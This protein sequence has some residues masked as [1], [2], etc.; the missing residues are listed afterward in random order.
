MCALLTSLTLTS[1]STYGP[2]TAPAAPLI[3]PPPACLT[4]VSVPVPREGQPLVVI[5]AEQR[6]A[7]L[8]ANRRLSCGADLWLQMA[9]GL[10][11]ETPL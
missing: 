6:A 1:C 5:A 7:A 8:E 9:A 4:P 3:M 11:P 2:E 10:A